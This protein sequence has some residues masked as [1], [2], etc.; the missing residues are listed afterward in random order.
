MA[1]IRW[2]EPVAV[3]AEKAWAALRRVDRAHELFAPV[4]VDGMMEGDIRTVTFANGLVVRERIVTVDEPLRRVAYSVV[5]DMFEHHSASM[6]ILSVDEA[7]CRF[8]WISDFLPDE[9]AATVQPLVEQ[10]ARALAR[11]IESA[12]AP[13]S[14][15]GAKSPVR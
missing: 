8:L 14:V 2:D 1:T 5:G 12:N 3:S 10:G 13:R 7:S 9:R 4:L 6:Q 11:N 15:H